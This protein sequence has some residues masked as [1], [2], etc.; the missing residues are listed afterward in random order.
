MGPTAGPAPFL[1]T[2]SLGELANLL[3]SF[4]Y[5]MGQNLPY[6]PGLMDQVKGYM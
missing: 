1:A 6:D 5:E 3:C 2:N 4:I